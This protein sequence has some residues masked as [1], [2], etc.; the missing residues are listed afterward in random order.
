MDQGRLIRTDTL[1]GILFLGIGSLLVLIVA[2]ALFF[3]PSD[4]ILSGQSTG[5]EQP[6]AEAKPVLAPAPGRPGVLL[7]DPASPVNTLDS[8]S[9]D[10]RLTEIPLQSVA[11]EAA[12]LP[13]T[14]PEASRSS[15][16]TQG[17]GSDE[18]IHMDR[19]SRQSMRLFIPSLEVDAPIQ[20]VGLISQLVGD[21]PIQ[22]W[23]V[24]DEYAVGWHNTSALPG[25]PGN[26]VLNG[27]NN[28]HGAVFRDLADLALGE[29]IILY[30]NHRS[31][32]YEITQRELLEERGQPLRVRNWN[33]RWILPTSDERLTIVTCWPNTTN[34]HR[35]VVIA[36]P[37]DDGG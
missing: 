3:T 15:L 6:P 36:Q 20:P 14:G 2:L 35:L 5:A 8:V 22:Q 37:V 11:A 18:T 29:Q 7:P 12:I 10:E 13:E 27:H 24:P 17:S 23:S 21:K 16:L 1:L 9:T 32:V 33:A 26:T 4:L 34:S 30:H 25:Q 28:V 31:Y 19:L